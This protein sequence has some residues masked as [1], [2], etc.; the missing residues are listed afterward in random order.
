MQTKTSLKKI[1]QLLSESSYRETHAR[2][3]IK[4]LPSLTLPA[5]SYEFLGRSHSE[6][7]GLLGPEWDKDCN[8]LIKSIAKLIKKR[9]DPRCSVAC[10]QLGGLV[11]NERKESSSFIHRQSAWKPW[12]TASWPAGNQQIKSISLEWLERVWEILQPNCP[13]VHLAQMHPH[14]SWHQKEV[15]AAFEDWLPGLQQLK[16]RFDPNGIL[17]PL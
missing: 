1:K 4:D 13:G 12:I 2:L 5:K 10:Q 14:M 15:E 6:V 16:Y 17:P 7:V 8:S 11:S 9:P 3:G